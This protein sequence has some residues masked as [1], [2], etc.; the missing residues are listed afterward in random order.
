MTPIDR[1]QT[2]TEPTRHDRVCGRFSNY[3]LV[4]MG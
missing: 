3:E 2:Q 4:D 1:T